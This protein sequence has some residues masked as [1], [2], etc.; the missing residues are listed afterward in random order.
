MWVATRWKDC[1]PAASQPSSQSYT[2]G[3]RV[4]LA[5]S[6][7]VKRAPRKVKLKLPRPNRS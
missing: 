2:T 6:S 7:R 3:A 4:A 5:E 1:E